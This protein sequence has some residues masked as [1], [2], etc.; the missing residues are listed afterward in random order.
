MTFLSKSLVTI[1]AIGAIGAVAL[2]AALTVE[3]S[4][5]LTLP[6]PTGRFAVGRLVADWRDSTHSDSLAP[7]QGTPREL[8]VWIWYPAAA[9]LRS[10]TEP[11]VPAALTAQL[12]FIVDAQLSVKK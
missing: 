3:R 9:K 4:R 8:L 2:V 10:Q 11:Y 5:P 12:D 1:A 6:M 7:R